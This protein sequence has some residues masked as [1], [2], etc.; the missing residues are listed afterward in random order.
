MR[1]REQRSVTLGRIH[2]RHIVLLQCFPRASVASE[3][4]QPHDNPA[5]VRV[6]RHLPRQVRAQRCLSPSD[7]ARDW[8]VNEQVRHRT[9]QQPRLCIARALRRHA[10]REACACCKR[11][12]HTVCNERAQRGLRC[13]VGCCA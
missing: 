2:A 3:H 12:D 13:C 10:Q 5:L 1:Q 4:A 8:E 9:T 7:H 6:H 11:R